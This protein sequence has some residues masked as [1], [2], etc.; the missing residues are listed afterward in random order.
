MN[1]NKQTKVAAAIDF[2]TS[3]SGYAYA[4][5]DDQRIVGRYQWDKQP[6]SYIKTLTQSLYN[7]EGSLEAWGYGAL[8]RFASL[9]QSKEAKAY[10]FFPTFKMALRESNKRTVDGPVALAHNGQEFP[11]VD[12]IA[13][14]LHELSSL[15]K[16][17][18]QNATSNQLKDHEIFWCLSVPAIWKEDEKSLMRVAAIQA[19]LISEDLEDQER[20]VLVLEPEA[21]ALYCQE[22]MQLQL[23]PGKRFMVV[24][25]GGGTVDITV[26]Q[27]SANGAL[28]EIATGT[29]GAYGSTYVDQQ[30][31]QYLAKKLDPQALERYQNED[32]I[33]YLELMA[34]WERKKCDFEPS[35]TPI[36]YLEIP[37]RLYKILSRDFPSVLQK[38]AMSQNGDDE[39]IHLSSETMELIFNP[40]LDGLVRTVKEQFALLNGSS[41]DFIYLVGGFSSSPVLRRRMLDEFADMAQIIMPP[42]PGSAIVEGAV[43]FGLNPA[44]IRSRRSRLTYGC[45]VSRPFEENLDQQKIESSFELENRRY[46]FNRFCSFVKAG[47]SIEIDQVIKHTFVPTS[48]E[49]DSLNFFFFA[50]KKDNPRY[51]DEPEVEE[52][53]ELEVDISSTVGK[54]NRQIEV[55]M[56]FGKTEIAV[57]A[58]DLQTDKLYKTK[59]R[60]SA[61]Y[62]IL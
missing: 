32:P 15:L 5:R 24:D 34:N 2:G 36:T 27:I 37:N 30:F 59:L 40:V 35:Q 45:N 47:E 48:N 28:E 23:S 58:R 31:S 3:C 57:I 41:C 52:L 8:S 13:D 6:F 56:N 44:S 10:S 62:A 55:S 51:V 21:A 49:Q 4:F 20:L 11:V 61:T 54:K 12:L 18:L 43:S 60:F 33:G 22:K 39:T 26:H 16:Q 29:G 38:L 46:M 9:K 50:T 25:C 42:L 19:G 53:G 1:L 17:E 14:Y 7:A